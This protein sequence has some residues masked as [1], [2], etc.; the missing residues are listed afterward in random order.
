MRWHMGTLSGLFGCRLRR[1]LADERGSISMEFA[2]VMPL[3]IFLS[4]GGLAFWDAFRSQSQTNKVAYTLS[5]IVG[6]Y[7]Q[8]DDT[9]ITFIY[10]LMDKMLPPDLDRRFLRISSIC[11][12]GTDYR[13]LWSV[14]GTGADR[15]DPGPLAEGDIPLALLPAMAAQDS[16]ILTELE[17]RWQPR[18]RIGIGDKMWRNALV[19]RP[20][21]VKIIPHT[22]L[23]P[24]N[25]CPAGTIS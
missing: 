1:A 20:R 9:D 5:D 13:V 19:V 24:S 11:F 4:V 25:I 21:F 23:N 8:V 14:S 12:N 15:P 18:L 10:A 22:R 2:I 3:L 16:V 7:E 17:A 6:R